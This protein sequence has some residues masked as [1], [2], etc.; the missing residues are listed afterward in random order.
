[1]A[2]KKGKSG[3]GP[4]KVRVVKEVP[5]LLHRDSSYA[6]PCS[7]CKGVGRFEDEPCRKCKGTGAK[8]PKAPAGYTSSS[9]KAMRSDPGEA[10]SE[11]YQ[12]QLS[13]EARERF[14]LTHE[15]VER[16]ER[17]LYLRRRIENKAK[18]S[19]RKAA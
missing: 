8:D 6:D 10:V 5:R 11:T 7:T 14:N 18:K 4:A 3:G 13:E 12:R 1:M 17:I 9:A 19:V 16:A 2:K 15:V